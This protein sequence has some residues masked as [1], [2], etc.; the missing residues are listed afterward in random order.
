MSHT[1]KDKG[2]L[3][4]AI[5]LIFSFASLLGINQY[6]YGM[7]NQFIALPWFYDLID[8]SLFP[9]DFLVA[10]RTS[11][12]SF[13]IHLMK[14]LLPLA[15]GSV[16]ILHFAVFV[17]VHI[18][19]F[20]AFYM[21]AFC[22]FTSHRAAFL[23]IVVL[24]FSFPIIGFISV[25]DSVLMERTIALPM[26]LFSLFFMLKK[27]WLPV[28]IL[29][30]LAFNI[31][32]LSSLYLISCSWLGVLLAEGFRWKTIR[33]W[34]PLFILFLPV[35]WFKAQYSS[36]EDPIAVTAEWMKVMRLRN[37]HHVFP[38]SFNDFDF[39]KAILL[40]GTYFAIIRSRF[41]GKFVR[42]WLLGFGV[43]IL[44]LMLIG[45]I[46]TE[47]YPVKIIM[48]MQFYRAFVFMVL[49]TFILWAGLALHSR[50]RVYWI[51]GL[52]ILFLFFYGVWSKSVA[53][54]ILVA[55]TF[56]LMKRYGKLNWKTALPTVGLYLLLGVA[57]YVQRED[58]QI[59]HGNQDPDW[60]ATQ[61]WVRTHTAP[62]AIVIVPPNELGFRVQSM[63]SCYG[64]WYDGTKAFFS[65]KYARYWWQRMSSLHCTDPARLK[66]QYST[67]TAADFNKIWQNLS[68]E[69]S[70]GYVVTYPDMELQL[71]LAYENEGYKVYRL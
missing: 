17:V 48:Q 68:K 15:G 50:N 52:P 9:G 43:G 16:P 51:L 69:Y 22:F 36:G 13:Y 29:Q 14:A 2:W 18:A 66:E 35:L 27:Q 26:L 54:V 20:T 6:H 41:F 1:L 30:G 39:I 31:H 58:F 61:N 5:V 64:D 47:T 23:A 4:A 40:M 42:R 10:Q 45:T 21:L 55:L 49:L 34:I 46:F 33:Y 67:N 37:A 38:D 62:D 28:V 71:P 63:R 44:L 65:E 59:D 12:P 57:G 25:W 7:W 32:P 70:E 60:Y 24:G 53:A 11:S 19:T 3:I 8:P 56:F